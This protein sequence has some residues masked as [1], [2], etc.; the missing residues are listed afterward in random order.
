MPDGKTGLIPLGT[1]VDGQ[2]QVMKSLL[3]ND[4]NGLLELAQKNLMF[5]VGQGTKVKIIDRSTGI[6]RV[7]IM[8]S[9]RK[10]DDDKVGLSGWVPMEWVTSN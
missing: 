6:R 8:D 2:T 1:T 7:R 4:S 5:G 9:L 10:V 3:A